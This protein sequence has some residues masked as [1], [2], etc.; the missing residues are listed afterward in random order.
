MALHAFAQR[1]VVPH[2]L[3]PRACLTGDV[4]DHGIPHSFRGGGRRDRRL[5]RLALNTDVL[6]TVLTTGAGGVEE[7]WWAR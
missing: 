2:Q 5:R 1:D 4:F 3:S 7:S 6:L